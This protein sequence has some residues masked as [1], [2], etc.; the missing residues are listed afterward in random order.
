LH[1]YTSGPKIS[2]KIGFW[3]RS[4]GVQSSSVS[5]TN[6]PSA[7]SNEIGCTRRPQRILCERALSS[8]GIC[9]VFWRGEEEEDLHT[10]L[11]TDIIADTL[12]ESA[13]LR[14]MY[15]ACFGVGEE[16]EDLPPKSLLELA[17]EPEF[18]EEISRLV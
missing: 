14:R 2:Y 3:R 17:D 13:L 6:H 9:G 15:A 5:Q 8:A 18:N 16:E 7:N 1:A 12:E 11:F 10:Y 4:L